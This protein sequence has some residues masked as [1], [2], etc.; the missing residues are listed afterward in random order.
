MAKYTGEI[1]QRS[2]AQALEY[3]GRAGC[4]SKPSPS[5]KE[6]AQKVLDDLRSDPERALA[7]PRHP[8]HGDAVYAFR[9]AHEVLYDEPLG[10]EKPEPN[11]PPYVTSGL[12]DCL[13][14]PAAERRDNAKQRIAE[15][16]DKKL[17]PNHPFFDASSP[18][19]DAAILEYQ[20][21]CKIAFG[22]GE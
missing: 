15:M 22:E 10:V 7:N 16:F 11:K 5:A 1:Y 17:F 4:S 14:A 20:E 21:L 8:N 18:R 9:K 3:Y 13:D 19:H 6:T 12:R 2:R